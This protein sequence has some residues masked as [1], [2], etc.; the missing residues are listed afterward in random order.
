M[1]QKQHTFILSVFMIFLLSFVLLPLFMC[2]GKLQER[3]HIQRRTTEENHEINVDAGQADCLLSETDD[4]GDSYIGKL[5]FLGESTT[6]GLQRYGLLPGGTNTV[7]VWTGASCIENSI[8]SAGT[9]SLSPVITSTKLYYPDE[10]IALTISEALL[11]KKPEYLVVT[12]GL[13]NGASYYTE[14]EFKQ[15]YRLLLNDVVKSAPQTEIILQ[16]IFPVART[17]QIIAYTPEKIDLCNRWIVDLAKEYGIKYLDTISVLRDEDGYLLPQYDNGGDG[18][19]LNAEGL[20]A[21]LAYIRT[22][23]HPKESAT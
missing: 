13:N 4:L 2:L 20:S 23:G 14:D 16:S 15:C 22:H 17:C 21:V 19:H 18:I 3:K 11:A 10:G 6:Y 1:E 9:L 5:I 7:Q 12:L 8:R